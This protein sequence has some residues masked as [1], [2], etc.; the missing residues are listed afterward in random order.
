MNGK[1]EDC[2]AAAAPAGD[3]SRYLWKG[4]GWGCR[5]LLAAVFLMAAVTKVTDLRGFEDAALLHGG[6]PGWL[7]GPVIKVLPWI[8]LT[9][10]ACLAFGCAAREAALLTGILLLAFLVQGLLRPR[11]VECG[12]FLF[13]A[14]QPDKEEWRL[15]RNVLLLLCSCR[16]AWWS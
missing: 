2:R 15:L 14:L 5:Y 4:L 11:G 10:G 1:S 7:A 12:C 13:P 3:W 16:V 6:L 9:C 8:E